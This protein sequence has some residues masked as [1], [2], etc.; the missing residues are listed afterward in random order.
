MASRLPPVRTTAVG[1]ETAFVEP[2]NPITA[3]QR[4]VDG[5]AT[6]TAG[7]MRH[8]KAAQPIAVTAA[9]NIAEM[10]RTISIVHTTVVGA[11]TAFAE[12]TK[13]QTTAQLTASIVAMG[14]A[15]TMR[16]VRHVPMIVATVATARAG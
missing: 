9:T 15:T 10:E 16:P 6:T 12:S 13:T 14:Y 7:P 1:A 4:I 11:G 3:V 8:P 2:T 5:V